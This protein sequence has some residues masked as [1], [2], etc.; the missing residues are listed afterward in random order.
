MLVLFSCLSHCFLG[1][2]TNG[3]FKKADVWPIDA[4][5]V[6][7]R[8][9]SSHGLRSLAELAVGL[10]WI[11]YLCR[12]IDVGRMS[13]PALSIKDSWPEGRPSMIYTSP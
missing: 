2:A 13:D 5:N 1:V 6:G 8:R 11:L 12:F 3:Q 7:P 10:D 4:N 9:V